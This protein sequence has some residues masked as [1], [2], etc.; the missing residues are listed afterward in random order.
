MGS[1]GVQYYS[2]TTAMH[3]DHL[4]SYFEIANVKQVVVSCEDCSAGKRHP[5]YIGGHLGNTLL[6][7]QN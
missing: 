7:Y 5:R 1:E 3:N 2:M 6:H 4:N